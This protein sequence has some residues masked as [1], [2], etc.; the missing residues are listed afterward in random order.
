MK[1]EYC[2]PLG[3]DYLNRQSATFLFSETANKHT[4]NGLSIQKQS[5]GAKE[6]INTDFTYFHQNTCSLNLNNIGAMQG[7][8]RL[9][10]PFF[11]KIGKTFALGMILLLCKRGFQIDPFWI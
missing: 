10:R 7:N 6:R 8:Y 3:S 5:H 4:K 9:L 11:I 2:L 1:T